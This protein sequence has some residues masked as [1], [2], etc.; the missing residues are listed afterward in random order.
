MH[1]HGVPCVVW[2][3]DAIAHYGVPTVV[4]DL[5]ILVPDISTAADVLAGAGWEPVQ[6]EKAIIGGAEVDYP[7]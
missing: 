7:Q 4:F 5:Y 2:F 1:D 3:E 6:Q